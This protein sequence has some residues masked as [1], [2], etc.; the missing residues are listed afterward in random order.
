MTR[1]LRK[2]STISYVDRTALFASVGHITIRVKPVGVARDR[3]TTAR[4]S[5]VTRHACPMAQR[6]GATDHAAVIKLVIVKKLVGGASD[7]SARVFVGARA[8][9]TIS[10]CWTPKLAPVIKVS[11]IIKLV[12]S[13]SD[14]RARILV[15]AC[16]A[17]TTSDGRT[18]KLAS[19]IKVS[20]V[21]KL[22]GSASDCR[23]RVFVRAR[24]A[25]T[26]D[27]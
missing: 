23:A 5:S 7:R 1:C 26:I 16:F 24:V 19:V 11:I 14:C 25:S 17:S 27:Y 10:H 21:I 6:R 15:G 3:S 4:K 12:G 8:A 9:S 13:A 22:A 20:I 2:R 18:T